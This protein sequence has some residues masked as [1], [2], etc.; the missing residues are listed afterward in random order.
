MIK[1]EPFRISWIHFLSQQVFQTSLSAGLSRNSEQQVWWDLVTGSESC[2]YNQN[3]FTDDSRH[4]FKWFIQIQFKPSEQSQ[5]IK[6]FLNEI[7]GLRK[8]QVGKYFIRVWFSLQ[9]VKDRLVQIEEHQNIDYLRL[10]WSLSCLGMA[11]VQSI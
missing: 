4:T 11:A 10:S 3:L 8:S 5:Q 2:V 6:M 1:N 7:M 9:D